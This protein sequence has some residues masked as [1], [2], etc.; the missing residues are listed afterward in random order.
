VYIIEGVFSFLV[1]IYVWFGLPNDP[2]NA[3]FLDAQE[4]DLMRIRA[5]QRA[6]YMGGDDFEWSEIK[7]AFADPKVYLR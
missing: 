7:I 1:A 4:R 6:A 5:R 2:S 3:Y